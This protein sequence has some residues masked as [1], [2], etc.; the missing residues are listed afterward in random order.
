MITIT[1]IFEFAAGHHLPHHQGACKNQHGHNFKLE[2]TV[3]KKIKDLLLEDERLAEFE[4]SSKGMV[5]DF[6]QLKEIIKGEVI[7]L[8]DHKY[9][10]DI[11]P[12]PTAELLILHIRGLIGQEIEKY[13][14]KLIRIRLWESSTSYAEWKAYSIGGLEIA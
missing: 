3:G 2:I 5:M 4:D 14:V 8:L 6:S 10:N 1:K 11:I 9:L 13:G 7:N 12:N